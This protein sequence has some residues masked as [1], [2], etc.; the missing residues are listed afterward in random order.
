MGCL[1]RPPTYPTAQKQHQ[2]IACCGPILIGERYIQ[3]TG[4]WESRAFRNRFHQECWDSICEEGELEFHPGE[5]PVPD[6]IAA[7]LNSGATPT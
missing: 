4:Y 6:R 5:L 7:M 3:Q 1:C 2:C